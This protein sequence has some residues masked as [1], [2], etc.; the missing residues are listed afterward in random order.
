MVD[1]RA[2]MATKST[3]AAGEKPSH[4]LD[5]HAR[6]GLLLFHGGEQLLDDG[7]VLGHRFGQ[8][9]SI[10]IRVGSMSDEKSVNYSLLI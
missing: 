7:H 9:L 2:K 3:G 1:G 5:G 6:L 4:L 8:F 10:P